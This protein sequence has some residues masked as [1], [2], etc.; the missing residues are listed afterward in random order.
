MQHNINNLK[1][2]E[3]WTYRGDPDS[4]GKGVGVHNGVIFPPL[5]L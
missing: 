3:F 1:T 5:S 2:P 4:M